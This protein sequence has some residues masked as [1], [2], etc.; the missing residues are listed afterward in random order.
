MPIPIRVDVRL[1]DLS[2]EM[3]RTTFDAIPG[4]LR[5]ARL[6]Y[7]NVG[8]GDMLYPLT[9]VTTDER[10]PNVLYVSPSVKSR[11][12]PDADQIVLRHED[13]HRP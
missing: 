4:N 5:S 10:E 8:C 2:A 7:V 12:Y 3:D 1:R 9:L 6:E 11:F 13:L